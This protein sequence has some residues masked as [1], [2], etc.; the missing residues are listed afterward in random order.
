MGISILL[1]LRAYQ[2][3]SLRDE[4]TEDDAEHD[5]LVLESYLSPTTERVKGGRRVVPTKKEERK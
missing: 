4:Y 2:V 5:Q 3:A 1:K